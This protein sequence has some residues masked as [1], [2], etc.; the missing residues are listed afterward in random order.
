MPSLQILV[1]PCG[2]VALTL[3][4]PENVLKQL[5]AVP[6]TD[7]RPATLASAPDYTGLM[8][9]PPL[10]P[11]NLRLCDI[12]CAKPC[13]IHAVYAH[14]VRSYYFAAC[15][16]SNS[17]RFRREM[18]QAEYCGHWGPTRPPPSYSSTKPSL[19]CFVRILCT[20]AFIHPWHFSVGNFKARTSSFSWFD[21]SASSAY[22]GMSI[23]S[24]ND[25]ILS[26]AVFRRPIFSTVGPHT[27]IVFF[28][29][30]GL[31]SLSE[32]EKKFSKHYIKGEVGASQPAPIPPGNPC[33]ISDPAVLC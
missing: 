30:E 1:C 5:S 6:H 25:L 24:F 11:A 23:T 32:R 33:L 21:A 29:H 20:I 9:S 27:G 2:V 7:F 31:V 8:A 19:L 18:D 26:N 16:S 4:R 3:Q 22:C 28:L 12:P 14:L 15:A 13:K 10:P 17:A